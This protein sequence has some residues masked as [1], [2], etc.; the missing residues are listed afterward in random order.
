[1]T[2]LRALVTGGAGFIG[3]HIVD[4]LI[5]EGLRV[6]VLDDLT[7]GR[8]E[9]ISDYMEEGHVDFVDGSI[10]DREALEKAIL[11]VDVVVHCAAIVS[12]PFS[13][14][15]PEETY[16]VNVYGTKVLL[17]QCVAQQVRKFVFISSC[18]V[19]GEVSYVPIDEYHPTDP[20]SP[21]AESKL[22][23]EQMCIKDYDVEGL[24]TVILRLFNVYGPRQSANGYAGVIAAFNERLGKRKPLLIY[25]DGLQ[26]RDFVHVSDV[27]EAIWLALNTAK[28]GKVFNIASGKAIGIRELA[29]IMR[30]LANQEGSEIAFREPREGD[31][32]TSHG[33]YSRA[34]RLLGYLPKKSLRRGLLELMEEDDIRG[35]VL[36]ESI[37]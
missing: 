3:S 12:V 23:A 32:R 11:D 35:K 31:I 25:G 20:L 2:E 37:T 15:H 8:M 19:Y 34:R 17:D 24:E 36:I 26:T 6:T 29:E 22:V 9:N 13:V 1:M 21:Y 30:A 33:D 28:T 7:S 10:L 27:A 5:S 18:A 16:E 4:R 14:V